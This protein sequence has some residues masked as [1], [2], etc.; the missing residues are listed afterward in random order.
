MAGPDVRGVLFQAEEIGLVVGD[1]AVGQ[2]EVALTHAQVVNGIQEVGLAHT[3]LT[4]K[5]GK[6][7]RTVNPLESIVLEIGQYEGFELQN[8]RLWFPAKV[9]KC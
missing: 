6:A 9:G 5:A 3:V 4:D 8:E 1:K 2:V 7:G